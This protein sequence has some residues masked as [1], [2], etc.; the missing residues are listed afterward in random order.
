MSTVTAVM[1]YLLAMVTAALALPEPGGAQSLRVT[2]L[3]NMGVQLSAGGTTVVIDAL[4]REMC[5]R[6]RSWGRRPCLV[7]LS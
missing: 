5:I 2:Y 7:W 4:H 6:D 1:K 3:A